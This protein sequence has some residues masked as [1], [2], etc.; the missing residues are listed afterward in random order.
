M[1]R[2]ELKHIIDAVT[3]EVLKR[4]DGEMKVQE[5]NRE[6]PKHKDKLILVFTGGTENLDGVLA[7]LKRFSRDYALLAAFTP[8]AEKVIG[9]ER[10]RE[11]IEFEELPADKLHYAIYEAK[12]II[13]PTL[14]QNTAA[15]AAVGIRDSVAT[16]AMACGLLLKKEVIAVTDSINTLAM[17]PAYGRMVN[18]ILR[19]IEQLGVK[20]CK[21]KELTYLLAHD[22]KA[23]GESESPIAADGKT[24]VIQER[25]P[26]TADVI[27]QAAQAGYGSIALIPNTIVTPMARDIA[28][29]KNIIIEWA[30]K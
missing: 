7:G 8:A 3:R 4:L 26:V 30:V 25:A 22:R 21:A 23:S 24:L 20:L 29:D 17:P 12:A 11:T 14:T 16:E 27:L 1:N 10:V 28:K 13:F 15:K 5:E 2:E 19:R 6:N 9:R 18:E